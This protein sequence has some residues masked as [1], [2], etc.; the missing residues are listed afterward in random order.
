ML[1]ERISIHG[2]RAVANKKILSINEANETATEVGT[3]QSKNETNRTV[4]FLF[5]SVSLRSISL[6][7]HIAQYATSFIA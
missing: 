1:S 3:M 4:G 7:F 5:S 2:R 6:L